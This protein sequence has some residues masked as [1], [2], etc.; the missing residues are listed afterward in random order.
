MLF[1]NLQ[2]QNFTDEDFSRAAKFV[3]QTNSY[4]LDDPFNYSQQRIAKAAFDNNASTGLLDE[5]KLITK[6]QAQNFYNNYYTK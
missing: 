2:K 3:L 1:R 5:T 6:E 4:K